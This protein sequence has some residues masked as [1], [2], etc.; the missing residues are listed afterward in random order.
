MPT[1]EVRNSNETK[2]MT[3]IRGE[4]VSKLISEDLINIGL[5]SLEKEFF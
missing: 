4:S 1:T 3:E 5:L 2:W